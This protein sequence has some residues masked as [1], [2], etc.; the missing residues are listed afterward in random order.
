MRQVLCRELG[1]PEVLVVEE[2]PDLEPGAGQVRLDVEAAGVNYVD[3]LFVSGSY[4]IKP[5]VPF[6]PG[7]EVA[8]VIGAVGEGVEGW[9]IG[10]RVLAMCGLGGYASQV[11]VSPFQLVRL[12]DAMSSGQAAAFTQS[13][14]TA[15]FALRERARLAEGES[16]LVLGAGG[17]VGLA[18]IDVAKALGAR[19]VAAASTPDKLAA[20]TAI[21]ADATIAYTTE[22]LK[23]A[24]RTFA[25]GTGID[26]V[27]DPVG[28][29]H[30]EPALRALGLF[31][32]YLVIGFAAGEI[33]RLPTNQILLR[34]RSVL[35]VDWGAWQMQ[36]PKENA[37]LLAELLDLVAAG[38]LHPA[39]PVAYPLDGVASALDDLLGR[40]LQGK[41]VLV[42]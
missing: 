36:F 16:V 15:L 31:G 39:E 35:G 24:A 9:A 34:N 11:V 26:V 5:P 10:D 28:G 32:R 33:P 41:A 25:G 14:C 21:G 29:P 12:P 23:D 1:P 7:S 19:V 20:A 18:T 42:P 17:G 3:A 22:D 6:T 2:A 38:R 30:A 13:Y 4:Q 27:L 37:S 40:R 8:G